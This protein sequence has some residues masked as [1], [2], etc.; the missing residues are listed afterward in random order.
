MLVIIVKITLN[1]LTV[2][3]Q[4]QLELLKK[5]EGDKIK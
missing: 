2:I 3:N 4:N 1:Y 5:K